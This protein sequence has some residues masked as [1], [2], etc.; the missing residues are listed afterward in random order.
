MTSSI[1]SIDHNQQWNFQ[2]NSLMLPFLCS[3]MLSTILNPSL[4]NFRCCLLLFSTGWTMV[5]HHRP[6]LVDLRPNFATADLPWQESVVHEYL[7]LHLY[8]H[9]YLR[10]YLPLASNYIHH[11]HHESISIIPSLSSTL[12]LLNDKH[13]ETQW[14][15]K[16]FKTCHHPSFSQLSTMALGGNGHD[17]GSRHWDIMVTCRETVRV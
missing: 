14:V 6:P 2:D 1:P 3:H 13:D 15:N 16:T 11:H 8:L 7:Y 12:N 10:L 9:L 5:N 17:A 4:L